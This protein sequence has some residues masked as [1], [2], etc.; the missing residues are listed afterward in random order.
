MEYRYLEHISDLKFEAYGSSLKQAFENAAKAMF[1]AM[2]K[3]NTIQP[4]IEKSVKISSESVESLLFDWLSE[5]LRIQDTDNI[6]FSEFNIQSLEQV[7][8]N[9]ILKAI[10][11]GEKFNKDK[12]KSE[13]LIKAMTYNELKIE[14]KLKKYKITI[15]MDI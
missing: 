14:K 9:W 11:K 8:N 5:L 6:L 13:L 3:I 12:H 15:V 2:V 7:N 1:N 4:S 10:V